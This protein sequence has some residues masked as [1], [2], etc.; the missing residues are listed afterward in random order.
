[1]EQSITD[2]R[3]ENQELSQLKKRDEKQIRKDRS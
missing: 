3:K 1:M 2:I